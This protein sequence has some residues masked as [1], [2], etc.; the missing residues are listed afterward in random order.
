MAI[1]EQDAHLHFGSYRHHIILLCTTYG[2][3]H[4]PG[5]NTPRRETRA[6]IFHS[7]VVSLSRKEALSLRRIYR[8]PFGFPGYLGSG[9]AVGACGKEEG[10][11]SIDLRHVTNEWRLRKW[12]EATPDLTF[13]IYGLGHLFVD[14]LPLG[15]LRGQ[16]FMPSIT[17]LFPWLP[18]L[19]IHSNSFIFKDK[20]DPLI[21]VASPTVKRTEGTDKKKSDVAAVLI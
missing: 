3:Q 15:D 17:K 12:P 2:P 5:S 14:M 19:H 9:N 11:G 13:E 10:N 20:C 4:E 1:L 21:C 16:C 8:R 6:R 7:G 18:G